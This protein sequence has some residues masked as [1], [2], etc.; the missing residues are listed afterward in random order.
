MSYIAFK[1]QGMGFDAHLTV[2]YLG[3]GEPTQEQIDLFEKIRTEFIE[4]NPEQFD[5]II[6]QRWFIDL[7]GPKRDIPVLRVLLPSKMV[8]LRSICEAYLGNAS[9][10]KDWNP[11]ITLDFAHSNEV[12]IPFDIQLTDLGLY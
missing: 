3:E 6:A 4:G 1:A 5:I 10:F 2:L 7:F 9:E 12:N 11:H 8:G